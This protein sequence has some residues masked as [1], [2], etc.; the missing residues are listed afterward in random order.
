MRFKVTFFWN[1]LFIKCAK[2]ICLQRLG[3]YVNIPTHTHTHSSSGL[4]PTR[5]R[6][7]NEY[8]PKSVK[9]AKKNKS[10]KPEKVQSTEKCIPFH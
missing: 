3:V 2:D 9:N 5:S 7:C 8:M 10:S 6:Q 1:I 4:V